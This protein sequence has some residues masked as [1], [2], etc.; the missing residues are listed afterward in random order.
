MTNAEFDE[1]LGS[2]FN[3]VGHALIDLRENNKSGCDY[4]LLNIMEELE[5]IR[6]KLADSKEKDQT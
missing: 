3:L 1:T 5:A 4:R 6:G 2:I